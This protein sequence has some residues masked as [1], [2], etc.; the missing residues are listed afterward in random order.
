MNRLLASFVL[1]LYGGLLMIESLELGG[2]LAMGVVGLV[3]CLT[4]SLVVMRPKRGE[5]T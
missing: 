4:Q 5:L 1:G 3:V 2:P